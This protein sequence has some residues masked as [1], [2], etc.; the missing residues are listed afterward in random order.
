MTLIAISSDS[1]TL[2]KADVYKSL[3]KPKGAIEHFRYQTKWLE[4]KPLLRNKESLLG[5][6][7]VLIFKHVEKTKGNTYIPIRSAIVKDYCYDKQTDIHH[8]YFKLLNFCK[9]DTSKVFFDDNTFLMT[10]SELKVYSDIWKNRIEIIKNYYYTNFFYKIDG[11]KNSRGKYLRLRHNKSN[12]SYFY[13]FKHGKSYTLELSV[14]NPSESQN[15]LSIKSSSTDINIVITEEYYISAPYDKLQIPITTKSIDSFNEMSFLS[16]YI[17]DDKGKILKEYEN[18]LHISK[19]LPI[20]K[21]T[22]F[23]ILSTILISFTWL[24][25][26]KVHYIENIF[27]WG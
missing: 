25:K 24:L 7:V 12:H 2:Y 18:H 9:F 5:K 17:K 3:A 27:C 11:I 8:Y 10:A 6:N 14:A 20:W 16:F 26:D 23:G 19:R 13:R 21:P 15:T 4:D 22:V 1:R